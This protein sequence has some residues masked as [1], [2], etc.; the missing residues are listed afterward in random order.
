MPAASP[1]PA[2]LSLGA[3]DPDAGNRVDLLP[4]RSDLFPAPRTAS[5]DQLL[6]EFARDARSG[7][8]APVEPP[9]AETEQFRVRLAEM[10]NRVRALESA[11]QLRQDGAGRLNQ[12]VLAVLEQLVAELRERG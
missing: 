1:K 3:R 8:L 10:E 6:T 4:R 7:P 2:P 9:V 11:T 5:V 12:R